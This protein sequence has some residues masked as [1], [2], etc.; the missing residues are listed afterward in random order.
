MVFF[1]FLVVA[2]PETCFRKNSWPGIGLYWRFHSCFSDLLA[3]YSYFPTVLLEI[4]TVL[5]PSTHVTNIFSMA[6]AT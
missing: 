1:R 6:T 3:S 2:L 5:L 4:V